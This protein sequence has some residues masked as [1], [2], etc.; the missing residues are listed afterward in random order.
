MWPFVVARKIYSHREVGSA[1]QQQ[2]SHRKSPVV[3]LTDS[4]KYRCLPA[5]AGVIYRRARIYVCSTIQKQLCRF[6]IAVLRCHMQQCC[7]S[8][9]QTALG[10]VSETEFGKPPM[11]EHRIGLQVP[12]EKVEPV[13]QQI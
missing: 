7:S 11:H 10:G 13:A 9:G 4:M 8:Q 2:P 12:D 3:E 5:D 6:H 1:I